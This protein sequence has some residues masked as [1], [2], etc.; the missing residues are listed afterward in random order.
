MGMFARFRLP[1]AGAA[2]VG[3]GREMGRVGVVGGGREGRGGMCFFS[4]FSFFF[5]FPSDERINIY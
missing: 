1:D 2:A 3:E 5:T 4:F